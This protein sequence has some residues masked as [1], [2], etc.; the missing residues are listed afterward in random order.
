MVN[1]ALENYITPVLLNFRKARN[2]TTLALQK[3]RTCVEATLRNVISTKGLSA[4]VPHITDITDRESSGKGVTI[5]ELCLFQ[6]V[7]QPRIQ[8]CE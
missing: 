1:S 4:V 7:L 2:V 3:A 5:G 6:E 8:Q